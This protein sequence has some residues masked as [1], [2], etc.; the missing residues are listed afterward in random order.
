MGLQ[1]SEFVACVRR[2]WRSPPLATKI[3]CIEYFP[4]H[5]RNYKP[6]GKTLE[7][8]LYSFHLVR[9]AVKRGALVLFMRAKKIWLEAVPELASHDRVF[10]LKNKQNV[11]VTPGNCPDGFPYIE[12]ILKEPGPWQGVDVEEDT[13]AIRSISS[14]RSVVER[15]PVR[16]P[17][18][19]GPEFTEAEALLDAGETAVCLFTQGDDLDM[20]PDGTGTSGYWKINRRRSI[21]RVVVYLRDAER[22]DANELYVADFAGLVGPREDGRYLIQLEHIEHVGFTRLNWRKFARANVNPVRYV[23]KP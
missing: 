10:E 20:R 6:L 21:D 19:A 5:S 8:Q 4:Y 18:R 9:R 13:K 23:S 22:S 3:C 14:S 2:I 12:R 7:S 17:D 15:G 1:L 11:S 16:R